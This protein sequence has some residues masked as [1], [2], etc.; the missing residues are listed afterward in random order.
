MGEI[1]L[2]VPTITY[3]EQIIAYRN[4]FLENGDSMDGTSFLREYE[5][6]SEWLAFIDRNSREETVTEGLVVATEFLAVRSSDNR[7]VGMIDVRHTLNDYLLKFGGHIGYC[8]RRS[9]WNQ[10]YAKEM[11]RVALDYCRTIE[12]KKVLVTCVKTNP[13][14]AKVIQFNGGKLENELVDE[15]DGET[16]QR[17]WI[18]L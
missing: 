3:E 18:T 17:Y 9:E 12:L 2:V 5:Q 1:K 15:T 4:E 11:L 6:V 10:G 14:S 8:V 16:V 13:A 7:L